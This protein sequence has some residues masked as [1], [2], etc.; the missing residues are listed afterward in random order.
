[1]ASTS[2]DNAGERC[3]LVWGP[4]YVEQQHLTALMLVLLCENH[5]TVNGVR[6]EWRE[7]R[8]GESDTNLRLGSVKRARSVLPVALGRCSFISSSLRCPAHGV[9]ILMLLSLAL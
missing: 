9:V 1:M 3:R 5:V 7:R 8:S 6:R 4:E 2:S